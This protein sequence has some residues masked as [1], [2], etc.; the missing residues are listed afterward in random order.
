MMK[1]PNA[2][3]ALAAATAALALNAAV[4]HRWTVETSRLHVEAI[5]AFRGET[6]SLEAALNAYGRPLETPLQNPVSLYWQTNGMASA[7]WTTNALAASNVVSAAF[8]P[9]YATAAPLV[10]GFIGSPDSSYRA[11]FTIRFRDA[12]GATPNQLP[13]PPQTID[14][15]QVAVANAPWLSAADL[16]AY[17][18]TN[19]LA[20]L[21]GRVSEKLNKNSE[22]TLKLSNALADEKTRAQ[23]EEDYIKNSLANKADASDLNA[24]A[25]SADLAAVATSG[26]YSDLSGTP[27]IPTVPTNVSAFAND[28][29]YLTQSTYASD[30]AGVVNVL[31]GKINAES[32][33]RAAADK[34]NADALAN[35]ADAT[36][37]YSTAEA[38]DLFYPRAQ[39]ELWSAWFSGDD[40]RVTVTNYNVETTANTAWERL[41]SARFECKTQQTAT[42]DDGQT[43]TTNVLRTVWDEE[44]KWRRHLADFSLFCADLDAVLAAK[45]GV[46][47]G[48]W[49]PTG[50]L[51]PSPGT[52]WIDTPSLTI[53]GGLSYQK[54]VTSSGAIWVLTSNGLELET[55]GAETNGFLR[56]SDDEGNALFEVVK[57]DRRILGANCNDVYAWTDD[58]DGK[59]HLRVVYNVVSDSPPVLEVSRTISGGGEWYAETNSLCAATT[60][61][62]TGSSG[63]WTNAVWGKN[64]ETQLFVKASY[65]T[66]GGT[67]VRHAAPVQMQKIVLDGKTYSLGTA[68]IDG[69]TVLTLT[70]VAQ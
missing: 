44:T 4:P 43:S 21:K 7:W 6:I 63:A 31:Q 12:P 62:W 29:N 55:S 38:D 3:A 18:T 47:W 70:E 54:H 66:G 2:L 42:N 64:V 57:G 32:S 8:L 19:D 35:K 40:F 65:S 23:S 9:A 41:P 16:N 13:L 22:N 61:G 33:Y 49:T 67:Y 20:E 14:F 59:T 10:R 46:N 68:A 48:N 45:A 15:A 26:K 5:E 52:T 56:I 17:A 69:H 25:K 36:N 51:N 28:A 60:A 39:G 50:N 53:A 1:Q 30:I 34:A 24:Y 11:A 58:A 37:V 27:A